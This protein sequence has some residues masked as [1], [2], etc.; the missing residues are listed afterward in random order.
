MAHYVGYHSADRMGYSADEIT[1]IGLYTN[2]AGAAEGDVIW[3]VAGDEGQPKAYRLAYWF[4]VDTIDTPADNQQFGRTLYGTEHGVINRR[5]NDESWF[6]AFLRRMGNF[7]RGLT[8]LEESEI[9][10]AFRRFAIEADHPAP[11]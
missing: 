7:G 11:E 1:D 3:V 8:R 9:L 5:L 6:A 10:I 2:K 4:V